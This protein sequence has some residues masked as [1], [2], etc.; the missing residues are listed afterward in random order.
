MFSFLHCVLILAL[1]I[2]ALCSSSTRW[3]GVKAQPHNDYAVRTKEQQYSTTHLFLSTFHCA[4]VI[5]NVIRFGQFCFERHLGVDLGQGRFCCDSI[6]GCQACYLQAYEKKYAK[7]FVCK[8]KQA[9]AVREFLQVPVI[10]KVATIWDSTPACR[11]CQHLVKA[12][13]SRKNKK[14][15]KQFQIQ[16]T[17][18]QD[19]CNPL[20][21][22]PIPHTCVSVSNRTTALQDIHL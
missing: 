16:A 3:V 21:R 9:S 11:H 4:C 14:C 8:L 5:N 7:F 18:V 22:L 19:S 10:H 13:A 20:K 12:N 1:C 2:L 6:A 17:R 15:E